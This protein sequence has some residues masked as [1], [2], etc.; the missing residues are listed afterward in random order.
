MPP[1]REANDLTKTPGLTP[2]YLNGFSP[3]TDKLSHLLKLGQKALENDTAEVNTLTA[4]VK[5]FSADVVGLSG[6]G[7]EQVDK[8]RTAAEKI[9][10]QVKDMTG[11][12]LM[13]H[14]MMPVL[15]VV[16]AYLKD[17]LIY[18]A[19]IDTSLME[20]SGLTVPYQDAV[21]AKSIEELRLEFRTKWA[22]S[23][24]DNDG[25]T[26]WIESLEAIGARGY[27]PETVSE[28]ET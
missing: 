7:S 11:G 27:R 9:A 18:A 26:T 21:N 22:R 8:I 12:V 2:A 20:R 28:M 6:S 19:G 15:Y 3:N 17:V 13:V 5:T 1:D 10:K 23:F 24:V 14:E 4:E 25:P 16:E